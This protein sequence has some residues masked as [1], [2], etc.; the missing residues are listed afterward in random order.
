VYYYIHY[1]LPGVNK[2]ISMKDKFIANMSVYRVPLVHTNV[3]LVT[4]SHL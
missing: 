2:E 4:D 3:P 1:K